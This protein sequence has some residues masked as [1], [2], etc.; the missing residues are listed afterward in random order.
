MIARW[1]YHRHAGSRCQPVFRDNDA[2][3][4]VLTGISRSDEPARVQLF[5]RFDRLP[6]YTAATRGRRI[7]LNLAD[8]VLADSLVLPPADDRLIRLTHRREGDTTVLSLYFRYLPQK[9]DLTGKQ[10]TATLLLDI[11]TGNPLSARYR[12]SS[13]SC[14]GSAWS[15]GPPPMSS[16]RGSPRAPTAA[17]GWVFHHHANPR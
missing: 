14:T 4:S 8:T 11:F 3:G 5:L 12:N 13:P 2:R 16:T 9:M 6:G 1:P 7:D 17:T 10:E 15:N